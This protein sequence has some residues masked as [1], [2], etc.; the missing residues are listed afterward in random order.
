MTDKT[1]C[2][3]CGAKRYSRNLADGSMYMC[4]STNN[5]ITQRCKRRTWQ[6]RAE[7]AEKEVKRLRQALTPS[8]DTKRAYS[9]EFSLSHEALD[10]DEFQ[11][12]ETHDVPWTVIKG[13]MFAIR[14][15]AETERLIKGSEED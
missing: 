9:G 5:L 4:G 11:Y 10:E 15:Q 3:K 6:R 8:A 2:P 7:K 13:I 14:K 1:H 12:T